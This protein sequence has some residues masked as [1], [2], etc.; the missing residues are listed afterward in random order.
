MTF[1][2]FTYSHTCPQMKHVM[3]NARARVRSHV[4]GGGGVCAYILI[5]ENAPR[6]HKYSTNLCADIRVYW[7]ANIQESHHLGGPSRRPCC[8]KFPTRT[9]RSGGP[10]VGPGALGQFQNQ[11]ARR[12]PK[13]APEMVRET[14]TTSLKNTSDS[15]RISQETPNTSSEMVRERAPK[16]PPHQKGSNSEGEST[17]FFW[18]PKTGRV[19][20]YGGCHRRRRWKPLPLW[21]DHPYHYS[22]PLTWQALALPH[23]L[24]LLS[25]RIT[26]CQA[27]HKS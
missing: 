14:F 21:Q 7:Q 19:T 15:P 25:I 8:S 6:C 3:H 26:P 20:Y 27:P 11:L 2:D 24:T 9:F 10:V 22:Q 16:P 13:P 18:Y 5:F 23:P 4:Q 12:A 17:T 1:P